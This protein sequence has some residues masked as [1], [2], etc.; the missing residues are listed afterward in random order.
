MSYTLFG[1]VGGDNIYKCI[2]NEFNEADQ[3]KINHILTYKVKDKLDTDNAKPIKPNKGLNKWTIDVYKEEIKNKKPTFI[4]LLYRTNYSAYNKLYSMQKYIDLINCKYAVN[5]KINFHYNEIKK[6]YTFILHFGE[7]FMNG[8]I[9]FDSLMNY[10]KMWGRIK[11]KFTGSPT[12][13]SFTHDKITTTT[14]YE[15]TIATIQNY[16]NVEIVDPS[17]EYMQNE[18]SVAVGLNKFVIPPN[19]LI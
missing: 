4:S 2:K 12:V 14:I 10:L 6:Q 9:P 11:D 13:C 16:E 7:I 8:Q 19:C 15:K 18:P 1:W 17:K 3:K 5:L